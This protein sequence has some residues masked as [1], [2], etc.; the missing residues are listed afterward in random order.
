MKET[1]EATFSNKYRH[2]KII[3]FTCQ[4]VAKKNVNLYFRFS[5]RYAKCKRGRI[6][7]SSC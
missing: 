6:K 4:G 7:L 5:T 2:K 3:C 1:Q